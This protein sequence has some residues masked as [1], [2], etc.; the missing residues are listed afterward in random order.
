[1]HVYDRDFRLLGPDF[2]FF[3]PG[4]NN[5][6]VS[7]GLIYMADCRGAG[8]APGLH[9]GTGHQRAVTQGARAARRLPRR[10]VDSFLRTRWE[11]HHRIDQSILELIT[12]TSIA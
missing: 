10:S 6:L 7:D 8:L 4:R 1:M 12:R 5:H 9:G 11:R 3:R 2:K